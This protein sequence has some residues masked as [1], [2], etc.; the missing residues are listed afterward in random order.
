[1]NGREVSAV[2][3]DGRKLTLRYD[4]L[5]VAGGATD[6]YFGHDQWAEFAPGMKTLEDARHLRSHILSAF[7]MAELATDPAERAAYLTF[8]VIGAGP[9]GVELAGQLAELAHQVLPRDYRS[10]VTTEARILLVEAG[11]AV[12][13]AFGPKLQRY[14]RRRLQ[15]MGVDVRLNTAAVGMEPGQHHRAGPGGR[16]EDSGPDENLGGGRAGLAAGRLLA[17]QP[18]PGPIARAGSRCCRTAACPAIRRFSPSGT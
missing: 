6:A 8:V 18:A 1:M 13:G 14:T 10:V 4:T 7:E 11:P 3:P 9:T 15:K 5:V 17:G 16:G 2:A 12:L